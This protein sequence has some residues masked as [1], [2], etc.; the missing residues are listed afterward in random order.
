MRPLRVLAVF[1]VL[2][3]ASIAASCGGGDVAGS[4]A[5][6]ATGAENVPSSTPLYVSLNTDFDSER[7]QAAEV[8]LGQFASGKELVDRAL[9][10]LTAGGVDFEV[11]VQPALGPELIV[12]GLAAS[13]RRQNAVLLTQ[14]TDEARFEELVAGSQGVVREINGWKALAESDDVLDQYEASLA[15][16]S[17]V[18]SEDFDA[19]IGDLSGTGVATFFFSGTS[20]LEAVVLDDGASET[21]QSLASVVGALGAV[22]GELVAENEGLRLNGVARITDAPEIASYVSRLV[23]L[24]PAETLVFASFSDLD[25]VLSELLDALGESDPDFDQQIGLLELGLGIS[26]TD[27][28]MPLFANEGAAIVLP[29]DAEPA[30]ALVLE[31]ADIEQVL[32]TIDRVSSAIATFTENAEPGEST[33]IDGLEVRQLS[34]DGQTSLSYAG[35]DGL[36]VFSATPEAIV[37]LR[38]SGPKLASDPKFLAARETARVPDETNGFVYADLER[39]IPALA[40]FGGGEIE[41]S[42]SAV[43]GEEGSALDWLLLFGTREGETFSFSGFVELK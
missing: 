24:A 18:D 43:L 30:V 7:W 20:I 23:E 13:G 27:D 2:A 28:L 6:E 15:E 1:L 37:S 33:T 5:G 4:A 31:V 3:G 39:A 29:G 34:I 32:A 21:L 35:Y 19:V 38:A 41:Q 9:A 26:V 8:L 11:D 16:G 10:D 14:P 17:L 12:A 22:A 42:A 36:L 40:T 25:G